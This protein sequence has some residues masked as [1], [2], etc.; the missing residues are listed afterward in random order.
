LEANGVLHALESTSGMI[1][2]DEQHERRE[3]REEEDKDLHGLTLSTSR[4]NAYGV[5]ETRRLL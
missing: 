5:T 4:A 1:D 3:R 2:N